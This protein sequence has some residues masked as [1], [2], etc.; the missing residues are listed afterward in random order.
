MMDGNRKNEKEQKT[1]TGSL[2][3]C[4]RWKSVKVRE[5]TR[6]EKG[7]AKRKQ[8]A[9]KQEVLHKEKEEKENSK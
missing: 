5:Q 3:Q 4:L 6:E 7:K 1:G 8:K 2:G 9:E